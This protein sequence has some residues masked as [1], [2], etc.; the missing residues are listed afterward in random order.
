M[1]RRRGGWKYFKSEKKLQK[2][3]L[4]NKTIGFGTYFANVTKRFIVQ[5]LMPNRLRAWAF[6]KFAR[7]S[8]K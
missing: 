8:E 3:M 4:E 1:Y 7:E 6:K 5:I 2:Y